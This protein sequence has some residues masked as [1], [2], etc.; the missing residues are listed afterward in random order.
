MNLFGLEITPASRD[1]NTNN[2]YVRRTEF[3][4]M[5]DDL[6]LRIDDLRKNLDTRINDLIAIVSGKVNKP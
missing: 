6:N 1:K 5:R 4:H 2:G 3:N